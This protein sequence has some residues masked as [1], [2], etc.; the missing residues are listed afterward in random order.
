M[1]PLQDLA[2]TVEQ[3]HQ[4]ASDRMAAMIRS[5]DQLKAELLEQR[6]LSSHDSEGTSS[7]GKERAL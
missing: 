2:K 1:S 5:L 3:N 4:E 7:K 6:L